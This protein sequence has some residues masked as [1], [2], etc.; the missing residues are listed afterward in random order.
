[1]GSIAGK[2]ADQL[3]PSEHE[4][5]QI[6]QPAES[7]LGDGAE[8]GDDGLPSTGQ[9][10]SQA[11]Q[12]G[13]AYAEQARKKGLQSRDDIESYLRE[14]FPKQRRDA[15]VNRLK[16]VI[17]EI[18]NN[19]DFQET[20][21]FMMDLAKKYGMTLKDKIGDEAQKSKSNGIQTDDHFDRALQEAK[22]RI[23][24]YTLG[25]EVLLILKLL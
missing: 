25:A 24:I 10:K 18:Q 6:D 5:S 20:V 17:T 21:D 2:A 3:R 13:S 4:T 19:P 9:L 23:S 15:V 1:M 11:K 8:E 7:A 12:K 14:K 16:R 22:V